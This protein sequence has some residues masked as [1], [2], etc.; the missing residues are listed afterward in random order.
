MEKSHTQLPNPAPWKGQQ[1]P[2]NS[3]LS[4]EKGAQDKSEDEEEQ[5]MPTGSSGRGTHEEV[6]EGDGT[7]PGFSPPLLRFPEKVKEEQVPP[8]NSD[9][10]CSL[11]STAPHRNKGKIRQVLLSFEGGQEE[12]EQHRFQDRCLT[13]SNNI[14]TYTQILGTW[15]LRI[16]ICSA[17][18]LSHRQNCPQKH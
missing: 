13:E 9:N 14:Y 5:P 11:N 6:T 16:S 17:L 18:L 1:D 12:K 8:G 3:H 15:Y 2:K 4:L 7:S 10:D